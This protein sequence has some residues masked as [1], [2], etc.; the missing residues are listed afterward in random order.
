MAINNNTA[1]S[2][3]V[4]VADST[5]ASE[6]SS[7]GRVNII[8][9]GA[10]DEQTILL[11]NSIHCYT[12][13][14]RRCLANFWSAGAQNSSTSLYL[15]KTT[16]TTLQMV[17]EW[18]AVVGADRQSISTHVQYQGNAKLEILTP[19]LVVLDDH[20]YG[21]STTA[22]VGTATLSWSTTTQV[23]CRLWVQKI[24]APSAADGLVWGIRLLEDQTTL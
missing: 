17:L 21:A 2:V 22:T 8:G 20:T 16:N 9:G 4:D 24:T 14:N 12:T 3:L 10:I 6:I 13:S 7:A 5:G 23:I 11:E 1:F 19:A 15:Y 18:P